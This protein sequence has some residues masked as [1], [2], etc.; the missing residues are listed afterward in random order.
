MVT[1]PFQLLFLLCF[2]LQT[3]NATKYFSIVGPRTVHHGQDY[4]MFV[5]SYDFDNGT[6]EITL[7]ETNGS[8]LI[9]SEN[10]TLHFDSQE[11]VLPVCISKVKRRKKI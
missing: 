10:Y 5:S 11:I 9:I 8:Y 2:G 4:K 7:E 6:I 3:F 1:K